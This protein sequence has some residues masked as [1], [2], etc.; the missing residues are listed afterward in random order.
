[1][2]R[3]VSL[4]LPSSIGITTLSLL[5]A[6]DELGDVSALVDSESV[7]LYVD[8]VHSK[9]DGSIASSGLHASRVLTMANRLLNRGH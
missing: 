7:K 3:I 8:C 5:S 1:M 2:K 4:R 9:D 6:E